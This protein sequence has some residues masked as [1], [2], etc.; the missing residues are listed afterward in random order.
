MDSRPIS[1]KE[2][3]GRGAGRARTELSSFA[4]RQ[5]HLSAGLFVC[6]WPRAR[7]RC[8]GSCLS[9]SSVGRG[10]APEFHGK[11]REQFMAQRGVAALGAPHP[12]W[13]TLC[14]HTHSCSGSLREC[15]REDLGMQR[16]VGL[17]GIASL[18]LLSPAKPSAEVRNTSGDACWWG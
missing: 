17:L 2:R 7:S 3:V 12:P 5:G 1:R 9:A 8:A 10:A 14:V 4:A 18:K 6:E 16:F 15:L 11:V 13:H